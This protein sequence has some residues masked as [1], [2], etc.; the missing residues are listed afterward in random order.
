MHKQLI[1]LFSGPC[2]AEVVLPDY[3]DQEP[4]T[5]LDCYSRREKMAVEKESEDGFDL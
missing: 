4:T 2:A 5:F 3:A 1:F